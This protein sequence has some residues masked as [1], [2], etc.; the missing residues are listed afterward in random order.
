MNTPVKLL[1]LVATLTL[2]CGASGCAASTSDDDVEA[3]GG[4]ATASKAA[5]PG[6]DNGPCG[7]AFNAEALREIGQSTEKIVG[8]S[9][10][11]FLYECTD[12]QSVLPHP[13]GQV[14]TATGNACIVAGKS[15]GRDFRVIGYHLSVREPNGSGLSV[16]GR[17]EGEASAVVA[18]GGITIDKDDGQPNGNGGR[19]WTKEITGGFG[20]ITMKLSLSEI[21]TPRDGARSMPFAV[22]FQCRALP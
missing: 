12:P 20:E 16:G 7:D 2:L 8:V 15:S 9:K 13:D 10:P 11:K 1:G 21:D 14:P 3:S 19:D 17:L 5:F 4:A 6:G 22:N 18:H